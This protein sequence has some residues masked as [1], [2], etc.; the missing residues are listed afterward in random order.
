MYTTGPICTPTTADIVI[1]ATDET[2]LAD[3]TASTSVS[4]T[5]A[6]FVGF[7][8]SAYTFRFSGNTGGSGDIQVNVTFTAVDEAGNTAN[9]SQPILFHQECI[10]I[11][12]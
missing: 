9:V 6:A 11:I 7:S 2:Q 5:T 3:V 10:V 1:T 8:G 12:G 4:G